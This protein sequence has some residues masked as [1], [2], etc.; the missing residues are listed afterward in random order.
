MT[1]ESNM[2][3]YLDRT[4]DQYIPLKWVPKDNRKLW[5]IV[6]D[7]PEDKI[8]EIAAV[9]R[10]R[11]AGFVQITSVGMPNPYGSLPTESYMMT[12]MGAVQGGGPLI[13]PLNRTSGGP[14]GPKP[15]PPS[16]LRVTD[17]EYT[18]AT[19][20]WTISGNPE[21]IVLYRNNREEVRMPGNLTRVTVGNLPI[22]SKKNEF[23]I[24]AIDKG[25][26]SAFSNI[27]MAATKPIPEGKPITNIKATA[28]ANETIYEADVFLPYGFLRIFVTDPDF[29]CKN[30]A[31]PVNTDRG[32]VCA[33]YLIEGEAAYSYKDKG[34]DNETGL[35]PW[36]WDP[37]APIS[38]ENSNGQNIEV[39]RTGKYH[40][41][42]RLPV[43]T[44][45]MDTTT[46]VVEGEGINTR[47]D[48]YFP[49]PCHWKAVGIQKYVD[50]EKEGDEQGQR[51]CGAPKRSFCPYDCKESSR[52]SRDCRFS[53]VC[54]KAVK[55][56]KRGK[57]I[58][59]AADG[60]SELSGGG[61]KAN[62]QGSGCSVTIQGK[63][64]NSGKHCEITGDEL[65][66]SYLKIRAPESGLCEKCPGSRSFENGCSV[67]VK[68]VKGCKNGRGGK[69]GNNRV[70]NA[71][72]DFGEGQTWV[73]G[74]YYGGLNEELV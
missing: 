60:Q 73:N 15:S 22:D 41:V 7:V 59:R 54:D 37:I 47:T 44:S 30:P 1:F 58:Y 55:L 5:H 52:C 18:S 16:N 51:Y 24:Q 11:H 10:E 43:G 27:V 49:C 40:Y 38:S 48:V 61:C 3:N 8:L 17:A 53:D 9:T 50:K 57:Q 56:I 12:L 35:Y 65:V 66:E 36:S 42:W 2:T 71:A 63:D 34:R 69:R 67:V 29:D 32:F 25:A 6:Y 23:K 33:K 4:G 14:V 68:S 20:E 74:A 21:I 72:D 39:G 19:L 70:E 26:E 64:K 45:T 28:S 13:M 62:L 46:I 31:Y